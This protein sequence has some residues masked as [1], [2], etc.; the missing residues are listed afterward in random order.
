MMRAGRKVGLFLVLALAGVTPVFPQ[1]EETA[2]GEEAPVSQTIPQTLIRPQRGEDP[3][4][5]QDVVIGELGTGE[6]SPEVYRF[7]RNLL[8]GLILED[9]SGT[10]LSGIDPALLDR[11]L[12]ELKAVEPLKNRIGG[13]REV[14]DGAVSFLVRFMGRER[15]ISG[16]LYL[17]QEE[18]E[19][20]EEGK[21]GLDDLVLEEPRDSAARHEPYRFDFSPYGRF[22]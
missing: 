13:G 22:Y 9:R 5:P 1:E 4:Y 21:W 2:E 3:R 8:A 11:L 17:R 7:A 12:E 16:E 15:W 10:I 19:E 14:A 6:A 18:G 20:G